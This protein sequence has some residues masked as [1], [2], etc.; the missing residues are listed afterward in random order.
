MIIIFTPEA[1]VEQ[2]LDAGRLRTSE[3]QVAERTAD[4]VWADI[5]QGLQDGNV[6][7]LRTV[8]WV[9]LKRANPSLRY[10]EF[11]PYEDELQIKL[12]R[13]E[14]QRFADA[15]AAELRGKPADLAAAMAELRDVALDQEH[16]AKVIEEAVAP[17]P[18]EAD[19]A[20]S[21]T[22]AD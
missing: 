7:A 1:G 11:D 16:A 8:A 17:G 21:S 18:K 6:T 10:S 22:S 19:A 4:M 14:V 3:I 9:L 15:L 13:R 5:R 12:D 2:Q 20:S